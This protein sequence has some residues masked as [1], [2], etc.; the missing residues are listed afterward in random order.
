MNTS[1]S[2]KKSLIHLEN[3]SL[4]KKVLADQRFSYSVNGG[5]RVEVYTLQT[6][7]IKRVFVAVRRK[8]Q[9]NTANK[10][11]GTLILASYRVATG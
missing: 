2:E 3:I 5:I 1:L 10:T 7:T 9:L 11:L 6:K 4:Q 8:S